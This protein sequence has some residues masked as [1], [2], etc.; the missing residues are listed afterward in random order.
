MRRFFYIFLFLCMIACGEDTKNGGNK[1]NIPAQ[2]VDAGICDIFTDI[3]VIPLETNDSSFIGSI[4]K[5]ELSDGK[6][7]VLDK[8][9]TKQVHIFDTVGNYISSIGNIGRGNGEYLNIE[10]FTLCNDTVVILAN[11]ST[12]YLYDN[13][14]GFISSRKL[15][16]S[17]LWS[18][19]N[20]EWGFIASTNH[21]TFTTGQDAYLLYSFDKSFN[22]LGK[23]IK[24]LPIYVQLPPFVRN[25]LQSIGETLYY[26]DNWTPN[27]YVLDNGSKM[28][29]DTITYHGFE[30]FPTVTALADINPFMANI[31][32]YDCIFDYVVVGNNLVTVYLGSQT[33][34]ILITKLDSMQCNLYNWSDKYG[35]P[36]FLCVDKNGYIYSSL[37]VEALKGSTAIISQLGDI[38][39]L[40]DDDNPVIL[41]FRLK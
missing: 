1:I 6:I 16:E 18:I 24:T 27:L 35:V 13:H 21:Q 22:L 38:S 11:S 5:I 41:K 36:P 30:N 2:G 31:T 8:S 17:L 9:S 12:V 14:G 33:F 40:K 37:S 34:K 4:S 20:T 32:Q 7:Y 28:V 19:T 10:D 23:Y 3:S 29:V 15:S 39:Y 26:H 25:P